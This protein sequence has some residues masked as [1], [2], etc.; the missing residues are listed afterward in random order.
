MKQIDRELTDCAKKIEELKRKRA[1][2]Q[3]TVNKFEKNYDSFTPAMVDDILAD[4]D[5]AIDTS[6]KVGETLI[7][8]EIKL[9]DMLIEIREMLDT[10]LQRQDYIRKIK[11]LFG[12]MFEN[13]LKFK[14]LTEKLPPQIE[15]MLESC[16]EMKIGSEPDDTADYWEERTK[17]NTWTTD[18]KKT[19]SDLSKFLITYK[20]HQ[21]AFDKE[22]M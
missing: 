2:H 19:Q 20:S 3:Q 21:A 6:N 16:K 14:E 5:E 1:E 13:L 9:D 4:L 17:I 7:Q 11:M 12:D 22:K 15:M 18:L 8:I 10:S